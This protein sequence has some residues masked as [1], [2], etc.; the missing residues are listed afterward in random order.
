MSEDVAAQLLETTKA[1][2]STGSSDSL[3]LRC[4][5]GIDE[6]RSTDVVALASGKVQNIVRTLGQP[7]SEGDV[8]VVLQSDAF[9][10]LKLAHQR[11]HQQLALARARADRL[12]GIQANL[13]KLLDSLED[14]GTQALDL[15][16]LSDLEIGEAKA[17]L[18][19]AANSYIR[20]LEDSKRNQRLI[21]DGRRLV[22][23][24]RGKSSTDIDDLRVGRWKSNVLEA[25][26]DR[27]LAYKAYRRTKE[28]VKKGVVSKSEQERTSRDLDAAGARLEGA[29][30][31]IEMESEQLEAADAETLNTARFRIEGAMEE[32]LLQLDV[33]RL[34]A[35][36]KV[37]E[38]ETEVSVSHRRLSLFG[39]DE[40]E[41]ETFTLGDKASFGRLEVKA[42]TTGVLISQEVSLGAM[43]EAGE[44]LFRVADMDRLWV[45]CDVYDDD[46]STLQGAS[47][48][49]VSEV[50]SDAYPGKSFPGQLDYL[51]LLTD[52]HS[53]TVKARV[54]TDNSRRL[55]R[56]GMFLKSRI[57]I[58]NTIPGITVPSASIVSDEGQSF[59]FIHWKEHYWVRRNVEVAAYNG[60]LATVRSGLKAGDEVATSGAFFLKSDVLREKM[61]AG[62]AD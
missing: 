49:V 29:L 55:L 56:P 30:E 61:G 23:R 52:E 44:P 4:E 38:Y 5:S 58:G 24:I 60:D 3:L 41:F 6:Q 2:A 27:R 19:A 36:Q 26:A 10:N 35:T 57:F 12:D 21:A 40:T 9:G 53:R 8:L 43:I 28:L 7:V 47:L 13:R 25:R 31:Q 39:L 62:C 42:P 54:I 20:A 46:L 32:V 11:V 34:E 37:D 22:E 15:E 59:V 17:V 14:I 16:A 45:W 50:L 1:Q 18:M 48:P 33:E 51:N